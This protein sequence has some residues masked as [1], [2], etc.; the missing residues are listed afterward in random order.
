MS[1]LQMEMEWKMIEIQLNLFLDM[2][3]TSKKTHCDNFAKKKR[4]TL[5]SLCVNQFDSI[6]IPAFWCSMQCLTRVQK[7]NNFSKWFIVPCFAII[8]LRVSK[9]DEK[10][11]HIIRIGKKC[12]FLSTCSKQRIEHTQSKIC[13]WLYSDNIS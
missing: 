6:E 3:K 7:E 9:T 13:N 10:T 4:P 12:S 8:L 1:S 11:L 5:S 2:N